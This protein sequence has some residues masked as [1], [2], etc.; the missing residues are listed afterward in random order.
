MPVISRDKTYATIVSTT[1]EG[2]GSGEGSGGEGSS[3]RGDA[4]STHWRDAGRLLT[5]RFDFSR[6][7]ED[8]HRASFN[9]GALN[10]RRHRR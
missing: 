4:R 1:K 9:G 3:G 2:E 7:H 10:S 8:C 6:I 5:G